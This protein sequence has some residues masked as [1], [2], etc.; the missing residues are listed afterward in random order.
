MNES[1]GT[2]VYDF[3]PNGLDA[4]YGATA[5][6]GTV[7][8]PL[9]PPYNGFNPPNQTALA[10][11]VGDLTSSVKVPP[12]NLNTNTVTI[13]MWIYPS[14]EI[15][16]GYTGLLMNR[17]SA[18]DTAGLGF[19]GSSN[20]LGMTELGYTWNTNNGATWGF[21]SQLY[22]VA[23]LWQFVALVIQSNSAT[24]YLYY[25]DSLGVTNLQSAVNPIAHGPEQF[26]TGGI[27]L[28]S[29]ANAGG[30]A[31]N[32]VFGGYIFDAAVYNKAL[33]SDQILA[34]FAA[35][36]GVPGFAP[37]I[38]GQ[39]VS[40]YVLSGAPAH[41]SATGINGNSPISYQWQL[42]GTNVNALADSA[43]FTGAHSNILTIL[44]AKVA[45]AGTYQLVVTNLY[46]TN[47]SS[48]AVV[49]IQAPALVGEWL[50]NATLA[51]TSGFRAAG[52]HDGWDIAGTGAFYFTNDVPLGKPG[53][54]LFLLGGTGIAISNSSTLDGAT[55][56]NT[57]DNVINN[58]FT[59]SLWGKSFPIGWSPFVSKWGEGPPYNTPNGGWQMR[60][61]GGGV[62]A[63]WTVRDLDAGGLVLGNT[64]DALD[65]MA[66]T[67]PSND[68]NWHFYTGT[69]D[70]STGIRNL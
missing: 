18:G 28:G 22:P 59:V 25:V 31:A 47:Y 13:S 7:Y 55:Y 17:T 64:G 66:T 43:N 62:D 12:L 16:T 8:G 23:D 3:S 67:F 14:A 44:S 46:G 38:T 2:V 20:S 39:P 15:S 53:K 29:D 54:S 68:G 42:N 4:T 63:C 9:A 10:C 65:D 51:E 57:F 33:S 45:D 69:Y 11:A 61:E 36:V 48:N 52:I 26:S 40:Q 21:N 1:G 5:A 56:T 34:L 35:G 58:A 50:T 70:V 37:G 27:Y 30:T 6:V 49:V 19:G 60:A 24:I 41:L 32:N